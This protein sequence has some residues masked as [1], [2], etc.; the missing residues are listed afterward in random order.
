[1][2]ADHSGATRNRRQR[3]R[4]VEAM[5]NPRAW[6]HCGRP[7]D[8]STCHWRCLM[9]QVRRA[10]KRL[11]DGLRLRM[12]GKQALWIF[13]A[14]IGIRDGVIQP[15]RGRRHVC[16]SYGASRTYFECVHWISEV[17]GSAARGD[18]DCRMW[19]IQ[20]SRFRIL[21]R[22]TIRSIPS[23]SVNGTR[24]V[25]EKQWTTMTCLSADRSNI[26]KYALKSSP[27]YFAEVGSVANPK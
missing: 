18:A 11:A 9:S 23:R 10:Q 4:G 17:C 3:R 15:T 25:W 12:R 5:K 14:K 16:D 22:A 21:S 8:E 20:S 26:E 13:V 19:L 27:R 7:L 6:V 2:P 24:L 1:M